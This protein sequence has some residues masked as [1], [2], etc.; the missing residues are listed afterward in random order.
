MSLMQ[1]TN[2]CFRYRRKQNFN[3]LCLVFDVVLVPQIIAN[4][5][6]SM[7]FGLNLICH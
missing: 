4:N 6:A 5:N 7:S 2:L 3:V 1:N